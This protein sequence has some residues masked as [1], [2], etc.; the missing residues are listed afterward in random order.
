MS[1]YLLEF[2]VGPGGARQ[3]D[4]HAGRDLAALRAAFDRRYDDD[5]LAYMT[6]WYGAVLHLW[7][8]Q[9]GT[10][11]GGFDL[12]PFLRTGDPRHDATVAALLDSQ[13]DGEPWDLFDRITDPGDIES[14]DAVRIVTHFLDLQARAATDPAAA[15]ALEALDEAVLDGDVPPVPGPPCR[16]TLD[17]AAIESQLPPLREPLLRPGQPTTF[18]WTAA[19]APTADSYLHHAD[20]LYLGFNDVESGYDEL[21]PVTTPSPAATPPAV[22]PHHADDSDGA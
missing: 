9:D 17:W 7:V 16:L 11:A 5:H 10:L 14:L 13:R 18:T 8:V 1:C 19:T 20:E 12:H 6:L 22:S 15:T 3:G 4:I 21:D 2:S